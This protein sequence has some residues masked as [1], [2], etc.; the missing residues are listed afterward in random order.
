MSQKSKNDFEKLIDKDKYQVFLLSSPCSIPISFARHTWFVVNKK[1]SISRWEVV[2]TLF[3]S[4]EKNWGHLKLNLQDPFLGV[5]I[6]F[7]FKKLGNFKTSLLG[8]VE[9]D[10]DSEVRQMIDLIESS[11][12]NYPFREKYNYLGP[13]SN[14]YTMWVLK[15]FK[16]FNLKL[17]WNAFGKDYYLL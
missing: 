15:H 12:E 17:P 6:F 2:H 5:W 10:E 11:P 4:G 13:N 1:G 7:F 8:L 9:G 14:T 16:N 3:A